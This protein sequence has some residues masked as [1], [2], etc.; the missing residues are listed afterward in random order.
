MAKKRKRRSL[1][2]ACTTV[3]FKREKRGGKKLPKSKW[4]R[5]TFCR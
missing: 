3:I 1:G 5:V 2:R 4:K